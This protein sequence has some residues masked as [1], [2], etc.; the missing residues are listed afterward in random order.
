[1]PHARR[2]MSCH[3]AVRDV[4]SPCFWHVGTGIGANVA[5]A[6]YGSVTVAESVRESGID[7]GTWSSLCGKRREYPPYLH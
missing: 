3:A 1:M 2:G 7:H 4:G 6:G 5:A